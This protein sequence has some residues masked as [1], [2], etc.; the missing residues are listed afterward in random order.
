MAKKKVAAVEAPAPQHHLDSYLHDEVA[1][2]VAAQQQ[3]TGIKADVLPERTVNRTVDLLALARE[4]QRQVDADYKARIKDIPDPFKPY[5]DERKALTGKIAKVAEEMERDVQR[6]IADGIIP[7]DGIE[8]RSGVKLSLVG[9]REVVIDDAALIPD[10]FLLPR[11]QCI[12]L[13]KLREFLLAEEALMEAAAKT[14]TLVEP[15]A[16]A[17]LTT[18]YILRT[19]LPDEIS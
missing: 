7:T 10:E 2:I 6:C 15:F 8:T 17:Q 9:R 13:G 12:D 5:A 19:K 14:G 1:S 3:L 11:A 4:A 16:G 18:S